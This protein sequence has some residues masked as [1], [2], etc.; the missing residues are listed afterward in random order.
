[1]R[2][3]LTVLALLLVGV[4]AFGQTF[5]GTYAFTGG[6]TAATVTPAEPVTFSAFSRNTGPGDAGLDAVAATDKFASSNYSSN[7]ATR[8]LTDYVTFSISATKF[9]VSNISFLSQ[10]D[11]QGPQN[12]QIAYQ[13][14]PFGGSQGAITD[15]P[16]G[17]G[18]NST[19]ETS[20][21]TAI[22]TLNDLS[23]VIFYVYGFNANN[24]G[25]TLTFDN[26]SV[27]AAVPE[28]TTTLLF[29]GGVAALV[30]GRLRRRA[31]E[32]S[33]LALLM[34]RARFALA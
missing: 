23:N 30:A 28:P 2:G 25:G 10:R 12:Y 4:P 22:T 17:S 5:T 29:G 21:S 20:H 3:V 18:T 15:L 24:N 7:S 19:S 16:S 11:N 27:V 9:S 34:N 6:S 8:D 31:G 14:T 26:V 33:I 1:M 13:A 32:E